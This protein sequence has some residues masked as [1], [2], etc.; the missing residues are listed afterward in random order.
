MYNSVNHSRNLCQPKYVNPYGNGATPFQYSHHGQSYAQPHVQHE[1]GGVSIDNLAQNFSNMNFRAPDSSHPIGPS[2]FKENVVPSNMVSLNG[3]YG[4]QPSGQLYYPLPDGSLVLSSMSGASGNYQ[5]YPAYGIPSTQ[6]PYN[7]FAG[8]AAPVIPNTP[9]GQTWISAQ[10]VPRDVPGL[11]APRRNSWSS[12]EETGPHTPLYSM[13]SQTAY[14]PTAI[15][16]E[17]S[18]TW[19]TPSP[20]G[21]DQSQF[22]GKAPSGH[23]TFMDFAALAKKDPEIPLAVPAP[24]SPN[25]G[26]GTL[27]KI[28]DNPYKTTNVYIR[29]LPPNTTDKMLEQYGARFGDIESAKSIIDHPT[30]LCKGYKTLLYTASVFLSLDGTHTA[31]D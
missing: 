19:S 8:S 14:Q 25:D 6:A 15:F 21:I 27:D 9:Q 31:N 12:S 26:R 24:L 22:V 11:V 29:G 28:L 4:A 20:P 7:A 10:H 1:N 18:S 3:M 23:Y 5:Q 2:R 30:D 16:N 17:Q 13:P